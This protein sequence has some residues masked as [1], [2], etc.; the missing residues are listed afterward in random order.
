[1]K[2]LL[3]EGRAAGILISL[4]YE[5]AVT[6]ARHLA[7]RM[8]SGAEDLPDTDLRGRVL[9]LLATTG[10]NHP[11]IR[12][13]AILRRKNECFV[14]LSCTADGVRGRLFD[15]KSPFFH[16]NNDR[17]ISRDRLLE[18]DVATGDELAEALEAIRRSVEA[19]YA[20]RL[21]AHQDVVARRLAEV[22]AVR[23]RARDPKHVACR[24]Y[25]TLDDRAQQGLE[26][27]TPLQI[28][29]M[30]VRTIRHGVLPGDL[31]RVDGVTC[32]EESAEPDRWGAVRIN[33]PRFVRQ[34]GRWQLKEVST[35]HPHILHS[36]AEAEASLGSILAKVE[37]AAR[38]VNPS[39]TALY[40]EISTLLERIPD[41]YAAGAPAGG[42]GAAGA[43]QPL[44]AASR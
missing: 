22:D 25:D 30:V 38:A 1:M 26:P 21:A 19:W 29:G 27:L 20:E 13:G 9:D 28:E 32:L 6:R 36:A 39:L 3:L 2:S 8:E 40:L 15:L 41:L 18:R 23:R 35:C 34:H 16:N 5:D 4:G 17:H 24:V 42:E 11:G 37:T 44:S 12:P 7:S 31:V 33:G 14:V 43:A 10:E